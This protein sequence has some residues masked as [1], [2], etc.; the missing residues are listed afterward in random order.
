MNR[1]KHGIVVQIGELNHLLHF[2][3]NAQTHQPCK[4]A[5]T[6]I[7]VHD[8]VAWLQLIQLLKCE[9]YLPRACPVGLQAVFMEAVEYLVIGE[10]TDFKGL[11][12]KTLVQ[13]LAYRCEVDG[14]VAILEN[15][16]KSFLLFFAITQDEE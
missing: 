7:H 10:T 4:P 6:M 16:K 14:F 9:G 13:G 3:A 12:G 1:Y 11:I 15:M 5:H 2:V 8:E